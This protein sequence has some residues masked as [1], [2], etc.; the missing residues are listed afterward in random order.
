MC[1][2]FELHQVNLLQSSTIVRK[3]LKPL[4]EGTEKG[5]QI[6]QWIRSNTEEQTWFSLGKG[7][8]F[9]FAIGQI[10]HIGKSKI[11]KDTSVALVIIPCILNK[12]GW[13]NL[14]YQ[15]TDL[16]VTSTLLQDTKDKLSI[17]EA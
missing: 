17:K 16:L 9:C 15:R 5:P 14:L 3:Y 2:K 13:P 8:F 4:K 7:N 12:E 1:I 6:S 10:V 11:E